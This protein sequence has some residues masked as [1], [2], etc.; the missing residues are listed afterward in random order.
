MWFPAVTNKQVKLSK[1]KYVNKKE[2]EVNRK[3]NLENLGFYTRNL[4]QWES[5]RFSENSVNTA[6]LIFSGAILIEI[7][8]IFA[9]S[10][11][12]SLIQI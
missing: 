4:N 9:E 1:V 6:P 12:L 3:C 5:L 11:G 8:W 10:Q 2:A 7:Q